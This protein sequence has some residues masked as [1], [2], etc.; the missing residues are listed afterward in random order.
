MK[1]YCTFF[2]KREVKLRKIKNLAE[3]HTNRKA[4]A[5]ILC[6]I[7]G[8]VSSHFTVRLLSNPETDPMSYLNGVNQALCTLHSEQEVNTL[9]L[10]TRQPNICLPPQD[11]SSS[12]HLP[13]VCNMQFYLL[14][15]FTEIFIQ[16]KIAYHGILVHAK[17]T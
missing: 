15:I 2:Q 7:R 17:K 5:G 3:I 10:D 8:S 11:P 14:S 12:Y 1:C 4:N 13:N 9:V 16:K 6:H